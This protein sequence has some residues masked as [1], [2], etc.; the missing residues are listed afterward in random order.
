MGTGQVSHLG[1]ELG[2]LGPVSGELRTSKMVKLTETGALFYGE[3]KGILQKMVMAEKKV[4]KL[5]RCV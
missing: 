5:A 1:A 2:R 4:K 3:A